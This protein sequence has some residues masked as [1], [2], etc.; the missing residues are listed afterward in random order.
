MYYSGSVPAISDG[1]LPAG[2]FVVVTVVAVVV[3]TPCQGP[4][5]ARHFKFLPIKIKMHKQKEIKNVDE[6]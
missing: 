1:M 3:E 2:V 6:M 5:E 4:L